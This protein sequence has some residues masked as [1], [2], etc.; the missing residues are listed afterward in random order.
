MDSI[1]IA[2]QRAFAQNA[3]IS[4]NRLLPW[5]QSNCRLAFSTVSDSRHPK[6]STCH[7]LLWG[8]AGGMLCQQSLIKQD[9]SA[10]F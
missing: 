2:L 9:K 6:L 5:P 1:R 3:F 8:V 10:P 4:F 7:G